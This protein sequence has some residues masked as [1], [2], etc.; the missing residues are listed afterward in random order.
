MPQVVLFEAIGK[1]R[2]RPDEAGNL[3]MILEDVVGKVGFPAASGEIRFVTGDGLFLQQTF[4]VDESAT[5][6]DGGSRAQVWMQY[7]V[8]EPI[9]SLQG[10]TLNERLVELECLSPLTR[11]E[12]G[13]QV[14]LTVDWF[15]DKAVGQAAP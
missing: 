6:P 12:P 13:E 1:P 15:V 9:D 5:Y 10:L 11:L 14:S 2:A 4:E 8:G 7:A 3:E